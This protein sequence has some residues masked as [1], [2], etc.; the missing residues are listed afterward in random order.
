M[1]HPEQTHVTS[2]ANSCHILSPCHLH[3]H[4]SFGLNNRSVAHLHMR[5]LIISHLSPC[6]QGATIVS[7]DW[8][9]RRVR[10]QRASPDWRRVWARRWRYVVQCYVT[11]FRVFML[12]VL[13]RRCVGKRAQAR[14]WRYVVQCHVTQFR[15]APECVHK[16]HFI[17]LC[18]VSLCNVS[19]QRRLFLTEQVRKHA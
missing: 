14:R 15:V 17:P 6:R 4:T 8:R 18:N 2:L 9:H 5:T 19:L 11:Q 10:Q 16:F 7:L 1:S 3:S 13:S 12:F